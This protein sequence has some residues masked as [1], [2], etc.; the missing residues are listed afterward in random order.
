[1]IE[2]LKTILGKM[3]Q[4]AAPPNG[5]EVFCYS[6]ASA[7]INPVLA[8]SNW[9]LSALNCV[10]PAPARKP[11][12]SR[13]C[14]FPGRHRAYFFE[15]LNVSVQKLENAIRFMALLR[16]TNC[17][18]SVQVGNQ[19]S[20]YRRCGRLCQRRD[21]PVLLRRNARRNGFVYILDESNRV[22]VY[23]HCEGSKEGWCVTSVLLLVIG[24]T[25][26]PTAR[27]FIN[28]QPAAVLSD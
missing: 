22:E 20:N 2:A 10:F 23:H 19:S 8:C 26:L 5:V 11:G 12:A 28:F 4:D 25:V 7:R 17:G 27:S 1:M 15:R 9:F 14:A 16:I 13:R 21:H 24:T 6:R 18:L 3:H